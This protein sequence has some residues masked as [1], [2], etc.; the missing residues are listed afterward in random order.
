MTR[1]TI[2]PLMIECSGHAGDKVACAMLTALII[3][4][5]KNLTER[6]GF[7]P[8]YTLQDGYFRIL[9]GDIYGDGKVLVDSF[10]YALRGLAE[11]RPGNFY[12]ET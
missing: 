7:N 5:M 2:S 8:S 4:L 3:G 10:A 6:L 1:I 11:S 12:I 9:T